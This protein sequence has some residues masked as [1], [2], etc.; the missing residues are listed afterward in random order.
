ME[1]AGGPTGT[2]S[3][4]TVRGNTAPHGRT[5]ST[6]GRGGGRGGEETRAGRISSKPQ[7]RLKPA[8]RVSC[9]GGGTPPTLARTRRARWAARRRPAA[10]RR[11][12]AFEMDAC[13]ASGFLLPADAAHL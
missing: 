2:P 6:A 5:P 1:W 10:T 8:G 4:V 11:G 9:L 3:R 13:T 7:S 12:C